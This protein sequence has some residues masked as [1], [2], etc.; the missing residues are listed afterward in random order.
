MEMIKVSNG[1]TG[2]MEGTTVITTATSDDQHCQ[3]LAQ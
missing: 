3:N 1:L 2:K